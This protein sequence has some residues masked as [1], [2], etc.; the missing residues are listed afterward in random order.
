MVRPAAHA[1]PL[2][3]VA[4]RPRIGRVG[5]QGR[6]VR[7]Y[8]ASRPNLRRRSHRRRSNLRVGIEDLS[9]GT[10]AALQTRQSSPVARATGG[11]VATSCT[12]AGLLAL[13]AAHWPTRG[14]RGGNCRPCLHNRH[15]NRGLR[16]LLG[17]GKPCPQPQACQGKPHPSFRCTLRERQTPTFHYRP[18]SLWVPAPCGFLRV[19]ADGANEDDEESARREKSAGASARDRRGRKGL[20]GFCG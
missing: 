19:S 18:P 4:E 7:R 1:E 15:R 11:T 13:S 9:R 3:R 12:G 6:V 10:V 16:R 5:L 2:K 20:P 14:R 8:I 17:T